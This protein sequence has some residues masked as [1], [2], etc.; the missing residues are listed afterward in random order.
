[1]LASAEGIL[2][3]HIGSL[4]RDEALADLLVT[5][6]AGKPI[7]RRRL[8]ELAERDMDRVVANQLAAGIDI[9]NDGEVGRSSFFGYVAGRMRGFGGTSRRRPILD[10]QH[11]PQWWAGL[12][13]RGVRR[14]NAYG[15]PAAIGEVHY[16]DLSGVA[17]E[18]A[19][20]ARSLGRQ[21]GRFS[22]TFMTAVAPGFLACA[23][24]NQH[25]AS[26]EA[27]V[28]ALARELRKEYEYIV[29]QG[30]LLQIDSPD[31]GIESG[32]FFQDHTKAQFLA[33]MEMHVAALNEALANVPADRVRFHACF[34]N[35]DSPHFFDLPYDDLLPPMY[36]VKA[37]ALALPFANPRH[38]HEID[39]LKKLPLPDGMLLAVGVIETTHNYVEHPLLVAERLERAVRAV[40]DRTRVIACTD[41]GFG[42]L[43]G[44]SFVTPDVTWAKL[45]AMREG[46]EIASKRLWG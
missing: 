36:G 45:K 13:K 37:G 22:E 35:R 34:G 23:M 40:G 14:I 33:V 9:G 12:Q 28:F 10:M 4:Q 24:E 42:T 6:G 44:D 26:H 17:E 29:G 25:Y 30:H 15:Q 1:M 8:A 32:G 46:A 3:T 43:A 41:C 11:F 27:Y 20:F 16:D 7:D 21:K 31:F 38:A 19:A 18:C 5:E 2:T 39:Y